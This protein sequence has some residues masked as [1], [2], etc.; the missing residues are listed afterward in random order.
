MSQ[1]ADLV[2]DLSVDAAD[3]KEQLP[4][5]KAQLNGTASE[6]ARAEARVRQFEASQ[7]QAA[8]TAV[9]Q[10]QALAGN[11]QKHVSLAEN[12]EKTR[13]RLDA[14]NRKMREEQAQ[15][16]A[17]AAAQDKAAAAFYRQIDSVKQAG[18]GLQELQRIQQQVRQARN[19]GGIAQQDY[20]ALISEVTAKT[21]VLAQAEESAARQKTA[22]IR[23]LKEQVSAQNLSSTEL[24]RAKAAQLGV[25]SAA[26]VYISKMEKAG[27]VTHSL[28]LKSAAARQEIG[29]L[30]GEIARGNF[31]ALRGSGITLANRA[32]WIDALMSP[33]GMAVGGVIGGLTAAVVGLG[34]AWYDGQKEGEEFNRQLALTGHYAGIT[35]GQLWT[36]SRA[37]SGNGITQHAAAGA[38]AQVVGSGAFRGGDIAMVAK[39]AAQMER[40]VGQSVSDTISQFKRLKDDPVNAARTL[41][42]ELH[43]L[44]ATQLEQ[45]RVLGEQGRASDAARIAM[46]ALAEETG[47]RTSDI[48]N[49]LNAL[50]STLQTLSDW[51]KQFWD[52]A[53]NIG[54][55]D[56]LDAQIA[57]LQE[58]I[59]RAKKSPWTNASTTVEYDQQRLDELQEKK[60]QKDLQ[61]AKAQ[62]ERNYQEQQKRRNA[63]NAALNRMNETEAARHQREIARINAMQYADQAVRDA[64]IQ[65]ENER[66]EKAIKKKTSEN[67]NDEATRLLLQY[68][69][70]QAQV[71]GQIAAARQSAGLTTE[72]MTEAHKQLLALQQRISDLAGKKLT[73]DE[74]SVLAHKDELIQALT[75]LDAKQQEL[76]KQT[77]L[78]D[79][80]K[81]SIQLASQLAEEERALRQQHD[82]DIATTGMGDKQ[83]QR[84]QTQFSLQQK[85][86]QQMEQL[87]RD[88]KQKGTYGSDEYRDAE[89]MLTDS[90]NRQLNENRRYWQEQELM[91]ADWK[92][93]AMRAF[94]NFTESA[95]NAAGTAEQMFTAAFNS[96]GNALATFCTTGKLNF[97]SFTASLLSD[98]A[99]I[100][101]QMAMMQ[102]VKGIG[103][104][105]GWGSAAAASVTPNADGGV[106]QSADLSRYSGTVVNRPTFFAFAKGA[107]V[108]GEAGPEAILPLRRGADG[109]LGV[110]AD[111]GG[112]GM[113][114]F[115]PQYNIEINNDG[116]NGQIGPAALK[117]VYDLGKKAAA[118]FMQQQSRDGGQLS[119]AYR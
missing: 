50:G 4:R 112:S 40:S 23:R 109:K 6:A 73:A 34:K 3:F 96:A 80:K 64:A 47:K 86:Q 30:I 114:M 17:L 79:L 118:D 16:A 37:I 81:K 97:K 1:I 100:M 2:I 39:A 45:I 108:M 74:K 25:S 83:R 98:L 95:D 19:N 8:T 91:Q 24:L 99:K 42:N 31:G 7:K 65:R 5:I 41:D 29:V 35:T 14:L 15:A 115:A 27:K 75:L 119:G 93:G 87:E 92:N 70:Q 104:A 113:V 21:R 59:Q 78:N 32:G 55:N 105:F 52:A 117:V 46:S 26:E 103:S 44:T 111:I 76:Q 18:A 20:L 63:E 68:S 67:R 77:A 69:Q 110:V 49:N 22:F 36:L 62:A 10:A 38:L 58:K 11:A 85:Y 102:A 88:S 57:A 28:G 94:Q 43:F 61:D 56:S 9:K 84:Y 101:S 72:K 107:G 53:M 106:Y 71:E 66:Y 60:R 13:Q 89:Q 51:W 116:T 12:V 82:L 33:K 48:D 54:R 90:L